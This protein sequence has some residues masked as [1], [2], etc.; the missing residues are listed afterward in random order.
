MKS[1]SARKHHG[2]V[3]DT[4]IRIKTS[5]HRAWLAWAD[6]EHIA[7]WFVDRAEG[8]AKPGEVMT[9]FF[10]TF[11]YRQPVPIVEAEPDQTFVIGS[12]DQPGPHGVPYLL[13]I[14]ITREGGDT[15]I[16]LVNSG[17]SADAKFDDE[18]QG[19]V[20]GWKGG[21]ATMKYWLEHH[22]DARRTHRIVIEPAAYTWSALEQPFHTVA[23]RR[24][25]LEPLIR[26]DADVLVDTGREVLLAW[27]DQKAVLGLKAFRMGPQPVVALDFSTW[28]ASPDVDAVATH[29][30]AALGRLISG[31][32]KASP[33]QRCPG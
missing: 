26:V 21:L 31:H 10:D 19:V 18:F 14:T 20:S 4:D 30:R 16:R 33:S 2:R 17:F 22:P 32:L 8:L 5:P 12:G 13:E 24:L 27:P 25:W 28:A 7:N 6:P 29:L 3:I 15:T 11:N 9:W 1:Q 23:G